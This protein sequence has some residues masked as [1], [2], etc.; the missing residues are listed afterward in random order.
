MASDSTIGFLAG[1]F[2]VIEEA[3]GFILLIEVLTN[4]SFNVS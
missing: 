2:P 3:D 4:P 1:A